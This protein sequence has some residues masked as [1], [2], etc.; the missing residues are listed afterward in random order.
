M[1]LKKLI[2]ASIITAA[3]C[4]VGSQAEA[5]NTPQ[6]AVTLQGVV[7]SCTASGWRLRVEAWTTLD[8]GTVKVAF[9]P[10]SWTPNAT[11]DSDTGYFT[12]YYELGSSSSFYSSVTLINFKSG[13][14]P[15][16]KASNHIWYN[17]C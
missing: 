14:T 3:L 9:N 13:Y 4:G 6:T 5:A 17:P 8:N 2:A 16:Y 15:A 7:H 1:R 11:L 12:R 10:A